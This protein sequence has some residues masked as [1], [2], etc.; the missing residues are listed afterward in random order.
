MVTEVDRITTWLDVLAVLVVSVGVVG[1]LWP[2]L[3]W[4]ALVVGG[5]LLFAASQIAVRVRA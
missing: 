2:W 3:G 4:F 5:L 1:G